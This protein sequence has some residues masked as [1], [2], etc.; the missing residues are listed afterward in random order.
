MK[1]NVEDRSPLSQCVAALFSKPFVFLCIET[2]GLVPGVAVNVT[3]H[4]YIAHFIARCNNLLVV[5][6]V[7]NEAGT[8]FSA[9]EN[10]VADKAGTEALRLVK[11]IVVNFRL[12]M[13]MR[14]IA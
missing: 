14:G 8:A 2:C 10:I 5:K 11:L 9:F 12:R 3:D 13:V 7:C 4:P 1:A 6:A